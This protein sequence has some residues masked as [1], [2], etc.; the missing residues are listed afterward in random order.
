[1]SK[2]PRPDVYMA[3]IAPTGTDLSKVRDSILGTF[4]TYGYEIVIIKVSKL[5]SD[6]SNLDTSEL[7]EDERIRKLMNAGDDLRVEFDSGDAAMRLVVNQIRQHRA[8]MNETSDGMVG[9]KVFLIESIKN[10]NEL[11]QLDKI[12]G[13]NLY[14]MSIF[15]ETKNRIDR[16]ARRI[17]EQTGV[18]MNDDHKDRARK[19]I[20]EDQDRGNPNLSQ[21]VINTFPLA[22]FFVN[23]DAEVENQVRR[24]VDLIFGKPFISPTVDEFGMYIAKAAAYRSGDLSR[25]VG[26]SILDKNGSVI[27]TGC[28]EVPIPGGGFYFEDRD[29]AIDNRDDMKNVD[30]NY[31]EIQ[32]TVQEFIN[33]LKKA[34]MLSNDLNCDDPDVLA[35]RLL[36]GDLKKVLKG[37]RIRSIIEFGRIV[38]AEMHAITDAAKRGVSID[39]KVLYCTTFP[40]HICARH[41][42]A[43]GL[44]RVV[45]I[46]PYPKS[47]TLHLYG[48]EISTDIGC[49]DN[50]KVHFV[51]FMGV[52]PILYQRLFAH[53]S[54]KTNVGTVADF[55][56]AAAQPQGAVA[57]VSR[58]KLESLFSTLTSSV[59]NANPPEQFESGSATNG[60]SADPDTGSG[61][62]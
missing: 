31:E 5:I 57:G 30:P 61:G 60:A 56:K 43:S 13:R 1:M 26:A 45:Y 3:L 46:E 58:L 29:N 52:A 38:H 55:P 33:A 50:N 47:Q 54:K 23:A 25:Q 51:P 10:T 27:T 35:G 6:Y 39:S 22:D 7:L 62:S 42:I 24:F 37:T 49:G 48:D 11:R 44:S 40:C 20:M 34:N 18:T 32:H 36:H 4:A 28:N 9:G 21:D 59:A 2:D 53:R 12:N 14:T 41:I 8:K 15:S 16:I 19:V 17:S